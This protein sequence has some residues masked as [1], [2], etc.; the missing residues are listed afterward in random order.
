MLTLT[1]V[2]SVGFTNRVGLAADGQRCTRQSEGRSRRPHPQETCFSP[3]ARLVASSA[4]KRRERSLRG[5]C[6]SAEGRAGASWLPASTDRPCGRVATGRRPPRRTAPSVTEQS[7]HPSPPRRSFRRKAITAGRRRW[8]SAALAVI[9]PT[10][11]VALADRGGWQRRRR[12]GR[13]RGSAQ[14]RALRQLPMSRLT[15]AAEA[16]S[17]Y[18]NPRPRTPSR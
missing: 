13:T 11:S 12:F 18:A 4:A 10:G 5:P 9:V 7:R 14:F 1:G 3:L 2:S 8:Q 16:G 17:A 15:W 6:F